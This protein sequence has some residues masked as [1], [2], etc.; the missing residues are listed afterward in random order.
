MKEED[1]DSYR[2]R[3]KYDEDKAR[4]YARRKLSD[5]SEF[6]LIDRAF[7]LI[8]EHDSVLDIPCGGGRI[9]LHLARQGYRMTGA[10]N[11]EAMLKITGETVREAG[12]DCAVGRQDI[13]ALSYDAG[14]FDTVLSFR[15]FHHFPHADIRQ[16][17]IEQ[18]CRIAGSRV[19]MSYY[20]SRSLNYIRRRIRDR[21]KGKIYK[22][23]G[24]PLSEL[25][26]YFAAQGFHLIGDFAEQR[27]LKPLHLAV[28]ERIDLRK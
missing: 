7:E 10:D 11:S 9:T 5:E 23:Y 2:E 8:P 24:L 14:S 19:V 28:F 1:Y 27:Y 15:L 17:A 25:T 20:N 4:R 26:G 3:V 16:R 12:F 18:V 6:Q 13:E 21:L 22:K